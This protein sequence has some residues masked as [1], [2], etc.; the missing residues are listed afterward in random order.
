MGINW[1]LYNIL[2]DVIFGK[3]EINFL[4][5]DITLGSSSFFRNKSSDNFRKK[6]DWWPVL[7]RGQEFRELI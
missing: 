6:K 7:P 3:R 5:N 4:K 1:L 2:L